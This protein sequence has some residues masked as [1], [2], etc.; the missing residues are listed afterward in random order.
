MNAPVT[1]I[2]ST[3]GIKTVHHM[4]FTQGCPDNRIFIGTLFPWPATDRMIWLCDNNI[5]TYLP[6]HWK[7][8]CAPYWIPPSTVFGKVP[9]PTAWPE[10]S[11]N[12]LS[13]TFKENDEVK[14]TDEDMPV[15]KDHPFVSN[16]WYSALKS[17]VRRL[18]HNSCYAC[19]M[20]PQSTEELFPYWTVPLQGPEGL[21]S[22]CLLAYQYV[23]QKHP[24]LGEQPNSKIPV[25]P[26]IVLN[27]IYVA[28][29]SNMVVKAKGL[30]N[31]MSQYII[32]SNISINEPDLQNSHATI[33]SV[34]K[35][36]PSL[37]GC[38]IFYKKH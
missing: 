8:R 12:D 24:L 32:Y 7:G 23:L 11:P 3:E 25:R 15:N 10:I 2:R 4:G 34:P 30:L 33:F 38:T 36:L 22:M 27:N 6:L 5:Y 31:M 19:S 28:K 37:V 13:G 1:C 26:I 17:R 16:L 29:S 35:D 20:L 18:T 9:I 14:Y 21:P